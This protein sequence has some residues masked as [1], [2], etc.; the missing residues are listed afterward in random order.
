LAA[1][2]AGIV[3]LIQITG[4]KV[5]SAFAIICALWLSWIHALQ[6]LLVSSQRH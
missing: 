6:S 2:D 4:L 1:A 3:L 5:N